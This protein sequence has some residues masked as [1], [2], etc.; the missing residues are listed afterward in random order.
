MCSCV[1]TYVGNRVVICLSFALFR[2]P[3]YP[4]PF[5]FKGFFFLYQSQGDT[6]RW[7]HTQSIRIHSVI[8]FSV[9]DFFWFLRGIQH[10]KLTAGLFLV[11]ADRFPFLMPPCWEAAAPASAPA[12]I[13][14]IQDRQWLSIHNTMTL[15]LKPALTLYTPLL[16]LLCPVKISCNGKM[17]GLVIV[18]LTSAWCLDSSVAVILFFNTH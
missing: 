15:N 18:K 13:Q 9:I 11:R 8:A 17:C 10:R 1:D 12:S 3:N 6:Q 4:N 5:F 14:V 16:F 2:L 7:C